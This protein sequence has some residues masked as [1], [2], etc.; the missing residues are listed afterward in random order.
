M[1]LGECIANWT[2]LRTEGARNQPPF[3]S[4]ADWGTQPPGL[5]LPITFVLDQDPWVS[6]DNTDVEYVYL[7]AM[8]TLGHA[9]LSPDEIRDAWLAHMDPNYIWVSDLRA[10]Q[11]MQRGIRP[12][13]TAHPTPNDLWAMID[14]QLTTEF[15]GAFSPGMPEIGLAIGDLPV[16]T[17]SFGFARHAAQ[18]YIVLYSLAPMVDQTMPGREQALWLA[19]EARKWIPDASETADVVDFVLADFLAN[20][21][22]NNWELTRDQVYDRYQLH[23]AQNGFLYYSW[24]ESTVNFAMGIVAL[25]YGQGDYKRTIQ[26][27]T[28]GGWDSDD[29]TATLGGV[30][31]LMLGYG[32][33]VAQFPGQ[34]FSDRYSVH[35]TRINLPDYL[36]NDPQADDTFAMMANRMLPLVDEV[37]I[38]GGGRV[39][40]GKWVL[41]PAITTGQ[42]EFNPGQREWRRSA[43]CRV[44]AQGGW[45]LASSSA[46]QGPPVMPTGSSDPAYF[47]NGYEAD[48][49]GRDFQDVR[50][51]AYTTE[52]SG[53]PLGVPITLQV[54]YDHPV[55]VWAVRFI[56]G[57]HILTGAGTGGWFDS[58]T[59]QVLV[60]GVWQT[61]TV[62]PSEPLDAAKP[63]QIIDYVLGTPVVATGIRITGLAGGTAGFV[64]CEELDAMSGPVPLLR[65]ILKPAR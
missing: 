47:A 18:Y 33:L 34:D 23:A 52:G 55:Q 22:P 45:V 37:V 6:D 25:L 36:P 20:P 17:T 48:F 2:G 31:G 24:P 9:L 5:S 43:N 32:K 61:P 51:W 42:V 59:V 64:T 58:A 49:T 10:Y 16:R 41:P 63:Y 56:E 57:D 7:H 14:A 1:W 13:M 19:R 62:T 3:F 50:R 54:L 28:L 8:H 26:I 4:D 27:G 30:L 38:D 40:Q 11:L 46:P 44:P 21:D 29:P 35:T 12:P 15:F 65:P 53:L 60:G 39:D